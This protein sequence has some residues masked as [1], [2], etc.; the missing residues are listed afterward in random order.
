MQQYHTAANAKGKA[1]GNYDTEV[2]KTE[3]CRILQHRWI[4]AISPWRDGEPWEGPS[5]A[6]HSSGRGRRGAGQ[7]WHSWDETSQISRS[8][9]PSGIPPGIDT[10]HPL[11]MQGDK[12]TKPGGDFPFPTCPFPVRQWQPCA[13]YSK[14]FQA[15]RSSPVQAAEADTS[16]FP[17][18]KALQNKSS[19]RSL[20]KRCSAQTMAISMVKLKCKSRL[21]LLKH[22]T[23]ERASP[24]GE[25]R[26][27]PS[28]R[29]CG[30]NTPALAGWQRMFRIWPRVPAIDCNA[31]I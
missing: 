5:A 26:A 16:A 20:A 10:K 27:Q 23:E 25:A 18:P 21:E 24:P 30:A 3:R 9:H 4:L 6:P 31:G 17:G 22:E 1:P 11:Q 2:G 19:P 12:D 15:R 8:S 7:L 14:Y 28:S 29:L 13:S